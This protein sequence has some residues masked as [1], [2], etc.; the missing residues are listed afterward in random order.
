MDTTIFRKCFS[1]LYGKDRSPDQFR[2]LS[3][4][5][6]DNAYKWAWRYTGNPDDAKDLVQETFMKAFEKFESLK[7]PEKF[8]SWLFTIMRNQ[9]VRHHQRASK[10]RTVSVEESNGYLAELE[11][12]AHR[13]D[14][15]RLY[16]M[17]VEAKQVH[18]VL[19]RL[20]EEYKSPLILHYLED[21]TYRQIAR[22]L[23]VPMGT[24]MSR[25]S[26]GRQA[27]KK[28]I[29]RQ[30]RQHRFETDVIDIAAM[31]GKG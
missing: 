12:T 24:V 18:D 2:S 16:D 5:Y 7:E 30:S 13:V 15:E 6:Y 3:A 31:K 27:L 8:K 26:R 20:S 4:R 14:T 17:K 21:F 25:L 10:Y 19:N 22:I 28:E 29:L 9:Y 11:K 23:N 1:K